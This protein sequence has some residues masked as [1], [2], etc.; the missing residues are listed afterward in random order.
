MDGHPLDRRGGG[1]GLIVGSTAAAILVPFILSASGW[2]PA[3]YAFDGGD[4]V[5]RSSAIAFP[6]IPTSV[7]LLASSVD[8]IAITA[9]VVGRIKD[10]LVTVEQ[11][12][13]VHRWQLA[14]LLPRSM[15]DLASSR[16]TR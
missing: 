1:D 2:W 9:A 3:A 14:E 8:T 10:R 6:M 16:R 12:L 5:V 13:H 4:L 11:Q 7:F 15:R